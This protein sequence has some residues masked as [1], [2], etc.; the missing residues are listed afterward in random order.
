MLSD[1]LMSL[2]NTS[3]YLLMVL[4]GTYISIVYGLVT[5]LNP[6]PHGVTITTTILASAYLFVLITLPSISLNH[7][8]QFINI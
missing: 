2:K 4:D 6:R 8:M 3:K 7:F 1:V 5:L